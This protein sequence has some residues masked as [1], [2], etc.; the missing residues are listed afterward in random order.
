[1]DEIR[2]I[3]LHIETLKSEKNFTEAIEI[4]QKNIAKHADDY[5]LYEEL[6]DIYLYL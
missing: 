1:M 6:A 2:N 3:I 4:L 5:R